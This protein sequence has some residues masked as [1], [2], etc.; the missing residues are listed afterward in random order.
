MTYLALLRKEWP[1]LIFGL[2][3]TCLSGFGQTFFI[4]IF[5]NELR[6]TFDLSHAQFGTIYSIATCA[7]AV[8]IIWLGKMI[9][10]I[11][12]RLYSSIICL[13]MVAACF[14]LGSAQSTAMLCFAFYLIRL[15]GQG[16][17][18]HTS[19]TSMARYLASNRGKAVGFSAMGHQL[20]EVLLPLPAVLLIAEIGWRY[21]WY[22]F[23]VLILVV[24]LPWILWL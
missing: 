18:G 3:L 1:L 22:S 24:V 17:M 6:A 4:A 10:H 19:L 23:G 11:D 20:S 7:S 8:S 21:S 14:V 16:L 15:T 5:G 12:L 9:D 13:G 2:S